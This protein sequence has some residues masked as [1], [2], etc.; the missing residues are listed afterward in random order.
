M[1]NLPLSKDQLAGIDG[2]WRAANYLAVG[3]LY[4]L[5]NPL[6]QRPLEMHDIKASLLGHWGTTL[7]QNFIYAHLNRAIID[8]VKK[9]GSQRIYLK[10]MLEDK[11]IDHRRFI[12]EMT[13]I[14]R[15][16]LTG[17]GDLRIT[18]GLEAR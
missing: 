6:L 8:R 17:A 1:M 5:D 3:Q 16:S 12:N 13:R 14:C 15:K 2:Y 4:L 9:T 11:L 7:G 10:Q 18:R